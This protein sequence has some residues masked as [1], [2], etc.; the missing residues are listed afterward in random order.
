MKN[1]PRILLGITGSVAAFKTPEL[2]RELRDRG[3]DVAA[4]RTDAARH[5]VGDSALEAMTGNPVGFDLFDERGDAALPH[6][7]RDQSESRQPYHLALGELPDLIL[8]AP[9]TA[10]MM[11]KMVQGV[12][13]DLLTTVLLG[14]SR[15]ILVAPA[16]NTKMW[17]HEATR[18][19]V[20]TLQQRGVFVLPPDSGKMA[21]DDE[22]E[23]AGR[24]PEPA[25]LAEEVLRI[26]GL[27]G[28]L[29]GQKVVVSAGGTEEPVDRVRVLSNRS[30]GRMG[31]AIAE[32]ARLRG[33]D[34]VFVAAAMSV[35]A[36]SGVRVVSART[37]RTMKETLVRECADAD[38][39]VMAA[40]VAD[41]RPVAPSERKVKKTEGPPRIELEETEDI[42]L[43]LR[44]TAADTFRVGFALETDDALANGRRKLEKKGLD[45][46][47]LNDA[48]EP[49]AGFEVSTNR[50]TLLAPNHDPFDLPL[51]SKREVARRLFD[52]VRELRA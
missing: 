30:S 28:E 29:S 13:D 18:E 23:G 12:A 49:G 3:A 51:L 39:L 24:L 48:T 26:H 6:W 37:A 2:V 15:P 44:D 7:M 9:A 47:V 41:W 5:F 21:W 17:E 16:M 27:A 42:L 50:V 38:V 8:V 31:V 40:A 4:V 14:T 45:L 35:P 19:N 25:A 33:A 1:G 10:S 11:A 52:R 20:A 46:L 34:V 36:P 43:A 32:E 22:G